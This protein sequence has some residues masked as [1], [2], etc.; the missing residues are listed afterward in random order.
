MRFRESN[1]YSD[2]SS[3]FSNRYNRL[4]IWSVTQVARSSLIVKMRQ[5]PVPTADIWFGL[6]FGVLSNR[7]DYSAAPVPGV[8]EIV[9]I[10]QR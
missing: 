3:F 5:L 9:I 1:D 2:E 8:I 4:E 7:H 6:T 10:E